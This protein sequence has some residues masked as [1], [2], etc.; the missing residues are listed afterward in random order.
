MHP[1]IVLR[2]IAAAAAY[3]LDLRTVG[4]RERDPGANGVAVGSRSDQLQRAPVQAS[5][6]IE[7]EEIGRRV[8]V[9]DNHVDVAIV[10]EVGERGAA[11]GGRRR[12]RRAELRRDV[13]EATV[14]EVSIDDFS[15]LIGGFGL[16]PLDLRDIRAR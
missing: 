11:A 16:Q 13:L 15:L 5:T 9:V 4:G 3:F 7:P 8:H 10:I 2:K 1:K 6:H 14:A 12:D